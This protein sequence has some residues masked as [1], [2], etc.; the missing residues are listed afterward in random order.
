MFAG[1]VMLG[2]M[3]SATVIV[4][5]QFAVRP[6]A[7]VTRW[8]TVVTPMG[9]VE[10]EAGPAVLVVKAPVQLSVPTGAV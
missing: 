10:P 2:A 3:L 5:E 8:V 4:K 6:A 1:Q 9:N 7:S